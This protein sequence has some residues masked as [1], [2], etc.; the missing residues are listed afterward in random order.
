MSSHRIYTGPSGKHEDEDRR[1]KGEH[2]W[3]DLS[4]REKEEL[5][6]ELDEDQ[7]KSVESTG[8][9]TRDT[10]WDE[11]SDEEKQSAWEE[12]TEPEKQ[13]HKSLQ[14]CRAACED[15]EELGRH[16]GAEGAETVD[17]ETEN[18]NR[19]VSGWMRDRIDDFR[20]HMKPCK[21]VPE[22]MDK[23]A[24]DEIT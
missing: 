22:W 1:Y 4:D 19:T 21:P 7:I 2:N 10:R 20:N 18:Q 12:L 14:R 6:K 13:A 8:K 9:Y 17:F 3:E 23:Y 5:W 24:E 15:Y 16:A 11:L